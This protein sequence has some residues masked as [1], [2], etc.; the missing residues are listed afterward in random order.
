MLPPSPPQVERGDLTMV[1][2]FHASN[3]YTNYRIGIEKPGEYK[4]RASDGVH[5]P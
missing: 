1:F 5:M 2:N 3:S 4:V